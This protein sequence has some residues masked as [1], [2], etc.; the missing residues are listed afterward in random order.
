MGK[1][2]LLHAHHEHDRVFETFRLMQG[3]EGNG[4][5]LLFQRIYV[6]Y[7]AHALQERRERLVDAKMKKVPGAALELV[8]VFQALVA[9]LGLLGQVS[10]VTC[11]LDRLVDQLNEVE[12]ATLVCQSLH[13]VMEI[14]QGAEGPGREQA[15]KSVAFGLIALR[16]LLQSAEHGFA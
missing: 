8:Q 4:V 10:L 6:G 11:A 13:Q 15:R 9:P 3:Y 1:Q 2:A 14:R 5:G 16:D 12:L 7:Q